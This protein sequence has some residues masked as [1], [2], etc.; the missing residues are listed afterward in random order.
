MA[1]FTHLSTLSCESQSYQGSVQGLLGAEA[2]VPA[3]IVMWNALKAPGHSAGTGK[4]HCSCLLPRWSSGTVLGV[5]YISSLCL[6]SLCVYSIA[7]HKNNAQNNT[8]PHAVLTL[9]NLVLWTFVLFNLVYAVACVA[10]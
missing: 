10:W 9:L 6:V 8:E 7:C 2:L 5:V 4:G 1:C 3:T